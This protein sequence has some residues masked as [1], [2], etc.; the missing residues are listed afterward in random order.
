M[1]QQS[2]S[3]FSPA[4]SYMEVAEVFRGYAQRP[5]SPK[6]HL[7][8]RYRAAVRYPLDQQDSLGQMLAA[9][10]GLTRQR[11]RTGSHAAAGLG[12]NL[13]RPVPSGGALYPCELY[14]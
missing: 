12:T 8:K 10:Y 5:T 9:I 13:M 14:L 11:W 2:Q 3:Q 6:P 4:R 1:A 7:W